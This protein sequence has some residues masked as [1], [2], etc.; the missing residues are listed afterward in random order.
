MHSPNSKR[1]HVDRAPYERS[2]KRR[3]WRKS[4]YWFRF[5]CIA[6]LHK[7]DQK[8]LYKWN[9]TKKRSH[10][11][12]QSSRK[13]SSCRR[14]KLRGL[15][16]EVCP[17][18]LRSWKCELRGQ[19]LKKLTSK[20]PPLGLPRKK[21]L[22]NLNQ[23]MVISR[24]LDDEWLHS[25]HFKTHTFPA[26]NCCM[27]ASHSLQPEATVKHLWSIQ[28]VSHLQFGRSVA[29]QARQLAFSFLIAPTL[30]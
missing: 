6:W 21:G 26:T 4:T 29:C 16:S 19:W 25:K 20:L 18:L 30:K 2:A 23:W 3:S 10:N 22:T 27:P 9:L 13:M 1:S 8:E 5:R 15:L 11:K 14:R 24:F 17:W 28:L 12:T 7:C